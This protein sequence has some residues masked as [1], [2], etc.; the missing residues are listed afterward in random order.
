VA[1]EKSW[2]A[3]AASRRKTAVDNFWKAVKELWGDT[4]DYS[5]FKYI[6]ATTV[7][8]VVCKKHGPFRTK[9]T[10]LVNGG[11]CPVCGKESS[12]KTRRLGLAAFIEK[13]KKIHG[14]RYVYPEQEYVSSK[15]K[16]EIVCQK[17][18]SFWQKP[19]GHLN[20]RG[21]PEC[22]NDIK[23]ACNRAVSSLVR[24]GL[25]SRLT[26]V[27][28]RWCYDIDSFSGMNKPLKCYC[29]DHGDFFAWPNNLLHNSGCAACG[30]VKHAAFAEK[31]KL[32]TG[33]WVARAKAVHGDT[34]DYSATVYLGE[35]TKTPVLCRKHGLFHTTN[36]HIHQTSGCPRCSVHLSRGE[37]SVFRLVSN[38]AEAQ[39]R[40]RS[41]LKPRELDIYIPSNSL[42]IEYCGDYWHSLGSSEEVKTKKDAH[43]RKYQDCKALG[44]RLLTI[45]ESE[46]L[47]RGYALRRLLRNAIGK[48]RGRLMARKCELGKPTNAEAKAF[49]ERYH[50]QG[51]DGTGEHYGLFWKDKLVACMRFTFGAND[52]GSTTKRVWTLTRYA[53]RITVAGAASRLFKA[54]LT[55]HQPLEV[56]SFSDNRYFEGGM[57]AQLGFALEEE[58]GPDY[59]VW[60]PRLGL[61]PKTHYQR[62][63]LPK[64]LQE[65]G[66]SDTFDPETDPRTEAEMTFLM[67][68]RRLYDCGKKRWVWQA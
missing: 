67:G 42:A 6:G 47:T 17:H 22:S 4:Y 28:G 59:Q 35:N 5:Q 53:T 62:R 2:A 41:L 18:G 45:Y 23:R 33:E 37:D 25:L 29:P 8:T 52:R 36:D 50:P 9:P 10:Y 15:E 27:N 54:F 3:S 55:E 56:K 20:G 60:S 66:A 12:A 14:D 48:A 44:I 65:H 61:R 24:D 30:Q 21:C 31:R 57:Y 11:G 49:Y 68:C 43:W 64:R 34:Y 39:Q 63:N 1:N 51:G 13:A 40:N 58:S 7:S 19:N 32:T 38:W 26:A 16:I 46:W